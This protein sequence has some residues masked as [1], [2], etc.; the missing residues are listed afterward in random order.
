E[1]KHL[2]G[3]GFGDFSHQGFFDLRL[4]KEGDPCP[5]GGVYESYRGIEV[6]Q[7]F[8]LGTKYSEAMGAVYKDEKAQEIPMVMGCYGIGVS[9]T[10]AAA[11]EQNHDDLGIIWPYPLA[12]FHFHLISLNTKDKEVLEVSSKLY[13]DLQGAGLEVL[14]DDRDLN[15]GVKFK[16][17]DLIGIPYRIIIG[18]RGLKSGELEVKS[19]RTGEVKILAP[20]DLVDFL[21]K[22]HHGE[23]LF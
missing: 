17:S 2:E 5:A 15:P 20:Q 18:A 22:I 14:W 4:A 6:G 23:G 12:P 21:K 3:V 9:R 16:D 13:Q 19:R 7:V 10:A 1:D 11:I 8:F